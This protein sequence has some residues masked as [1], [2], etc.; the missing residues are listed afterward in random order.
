MYTKGLLD[1]VPCQP[2]LLISHP[3]YPTAYCLL[4]LWW[5]TACLCSKPMQPTSVPL[6]FILVHTTAFCPD[7]QCRSLVE[8][9]DQSSPWLRLIMCCSLSLPYVSHIYTRMASPI[10]AVGEEAIISLLLLLLSCF[11]RVRLCN[12]ID[13]SPPGSPILGIL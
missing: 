4:L 2:F 7:V 8:N 12:P 3:T 1:T 6:C 10:T 13:D 11:S 9:L 5:N